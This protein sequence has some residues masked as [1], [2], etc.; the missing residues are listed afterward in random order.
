M[1]ITILTC[2]FQ[3]PSQFHLLCSLLPVPDAATP[4]KC[5]ITKV[6][7]YTYL[8]FDIIKCNDRGSNNIVQDEYIQFLLIFMEKSV[9]KL[10]FEMLSN[11]NWLTR[12]IIKLVMRKLNVMF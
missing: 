12:S 9:L 1:Y 6:I 4:S 3:L 5:P 7:C 2:K 11:V 10:T 8:Y